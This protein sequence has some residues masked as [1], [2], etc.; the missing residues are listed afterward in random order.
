MNYVELAKYVDDLQRSGFDT[1]KLRVQYYKKF[2]VPLF[3]LIM[4]M[5][6]IPFGFMVGN[7]GAMAGIGV[8][9]AVAMAYL[10][11]GQLFDQIGNVSY[12]PP[13]LAAWAPDGLFSLTGLYLMLRM[14][15]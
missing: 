10:G 6:S 8:S 14:R 3:G 11:V 15:S 9:I 7:R 2:A 1:V 13:Q 4:A 5:I 12:L